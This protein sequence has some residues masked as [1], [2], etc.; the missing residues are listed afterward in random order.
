M[1]ESTIVNNLIQKKKFISF[2]V[3]LGCYKNSPTRPRKRNTLGQA[4]QD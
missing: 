4:G 3:I 1:T 2:D